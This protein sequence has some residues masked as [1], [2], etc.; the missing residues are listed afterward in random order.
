MAGATGIGDWTTWLKIAS[1]YCIAYFVLTTLLILDVETLRNAL[2]TW[3]PRF[4]NSSLNEFLY[5]IIVRRHRVENGYQRSFMR[6]AR[7]AISWL[8]VWTVYL[9]CVF[10]SLQ[11]S[12]RPRLAADPKALSDVV[13]VFAEQAM[14][15][16]P[17][18]FYY[19]GRKSLDP[20]KVALVSFWI[21]VAFQL[22][23]GLLVIRRIHRFWAS[24]RTVQV[25]QQGQTRPLLPGASSD[26]RD[27]LAT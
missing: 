15:Y 24:S 20:A 5:G 21:L 19:V 12:F 2:L 10:T 16:V 18:V 13:Q 11:T 17:V 8:I 14:L 22:I 23:M 26:G 9:V 4:R 1:F 6:R 7:G 27:G 3:S 25:E